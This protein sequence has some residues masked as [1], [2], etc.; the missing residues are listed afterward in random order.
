MSK[1]Y[2]LCCALEHS[3]NCPNGESTTFGLDIHL[4]AKHTPDRAGHDSA[5]RCKTFKGLRYMWTV[6]LR[7]FH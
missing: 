5:H 7:N 1:E 4:R 3:K 6:R 2:C